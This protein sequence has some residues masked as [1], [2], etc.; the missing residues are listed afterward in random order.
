MLVTQRSNRW[1]RR[2]GILSGTLKQLRRGLERRGIQF[3]KSAT[4]LQ[5]QAGSGSPLDLVYA[6]SATSRNSLKLHGTDRTLHHTT[7]HTHFPPYWTFS[8]PSDNRFNLVI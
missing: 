3:A 2:L 5:E 8:G 6:I 1:T 7:L 4:D